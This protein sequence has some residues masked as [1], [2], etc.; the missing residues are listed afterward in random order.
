MNYNFENALLSDWLFEMQVPAQL[1]RQPYLDQK[2][3]SIIKLACDTFNQNVAVFFMTVDVTEQYVHL[4]NI[5]QEKIE[6][7]FLVVC[8]VIF[9]M[10][11]Y[12]G[13]GGDLNLSLVEKFMVRISRE[14]YNQKAILQMEF[15]ILKTLDCKLP[16]STAFDD[17][18]IFFENFI[19]E[20][21]QQELLRPLCFETLILIYC[22]KQKWFE[23]MKGIYGE[24]TE[25]FEYLLSSKFFLPAG[26]LISALKMTNFHFI[27]DIDG[28]LQDLRVFTKIH[29]Y[30]I[31]M[32]SNCILD[33]MKA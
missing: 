1:C 28:I 16:F 15:E 19:R 8:T 5:R 13:G 12:H 9:M 17:F 2:V 22:M 27:L 26:I 10:S 32:L 7:P 11:K 6:D 23:T 14:N 25:T 21:R 3:T 31:S 18:N 33:L 29:P 4:K 24:D 20:Y 30:H